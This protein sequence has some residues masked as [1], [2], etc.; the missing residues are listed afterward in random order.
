M[1]A[2]GKPPVPP[3]PWPNGSLPIIIPDDLDAWPCKKHTGRALD[4]L[5]AAHR[6]GFMGVRVHRSREA[7]CRGFF[8]FEFNEH[9]P[10]GQVLQRVMALAKAG[11]SEPPEVVLATIRQIYRERGLKLPVKREGS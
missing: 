3:S 8:R 2:A 10:E 9:R 1:S 5:V 11:C 4:T 6:A 7:T